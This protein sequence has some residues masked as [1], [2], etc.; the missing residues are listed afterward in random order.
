MTARRATL[1]YLTLVAAAAALAVSACSS[2]DDRSAPAGL[3][4]AR[5]AVDAH[6][7]AARAYDLEADCNLRTPERLAEMAS[8]DQLEA[9]TYCATVTAPIIEAADAETRER[10]RTIYTNPTVTKLDRPGGTWFSVVSADGAYTEDVE[11]VSV[12]GRWWI[13]TIESDVYDS[14]HDHGHEA[15]EEAPPDTPAASDGSTPT[16]AD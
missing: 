5:A 15:D 4:S 7:E 3:E 12:D 8:Y 11:T 10:S 14:D 2:D 1:R 16:S 13:G 9:D 6:I